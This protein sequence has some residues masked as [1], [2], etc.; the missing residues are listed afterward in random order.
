MRAICNYTGID[1]SDR[2]LDYALCKNVT[3]DI[4]LPNHSRGIKQ[5]KIGSLSRRKSYDIFANEIKNNTKSLEIN[6]LLDYK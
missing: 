1:Y 4:D 5:G 3:G 2:F 6:H